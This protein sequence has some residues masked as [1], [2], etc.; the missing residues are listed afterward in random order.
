V[1]SARAQGFRGTSKTGDGEAIKWQEICAVHEAAVE[2]ACSR[3][4][5]AGGAILVQLM[6]M[7]IRGL[8]RNMRLS[9]MTQERQGGGEDNWVS[10]DLMLQVQAIGMVVLASG[11]LGLRN[12]FSRQ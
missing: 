4:T 12:L 7:L 3:I 8:S 5:D 6:S 11:D 1:V 9:M 10:K 2:K